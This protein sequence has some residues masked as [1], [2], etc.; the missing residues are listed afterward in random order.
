MSGF[1]TIFDKRANKKSHYKFNN[2]LAW[3]KNIFVADGPAMAEELF[4]IISGVL[5]SKSK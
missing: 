1:K 5:K 4:Q 3:Y 2:K